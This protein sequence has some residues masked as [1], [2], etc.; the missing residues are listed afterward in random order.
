MGAVNVNSI[1]FHGHLVT[2][3]GEVPLKTVE[4]IAKGLGEKAKP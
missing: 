1:D 4:L 3:M 2:V